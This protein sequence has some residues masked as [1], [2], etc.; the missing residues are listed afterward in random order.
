M[1]GCRTVKVALL[2]DC[3]LPRLGGI[4]VQVHD[5]A[6]AL[7]AAGHAVEVFTATA[8]PNGERHGACLV[9]G[10]V[11]VHRMAIPLPGGVPVN[12]FAPPEVRRRLREGGFDV[13]HIHMGVV[14]PFATDMVRVALGLGVPTAITWHCVIDRSAPAFRALG[15]VRRWAARGAALSA[16]STMAADRI[17]VVAGAGVH[18][19]V[20]GNGID[21]DAWARPAALA[22][23]DPSGPVRVVS[24]LRLARRKRPLAVLETLRRARGLVD[25][26]VELEATILGDGPQRA[27]LER[28]LSRHAMGWVSLPGRVSREEL[29]RLHW[30]SD[31]YLSTAR[32]EAFGIAALEARTAGLPVVARRGTGADDFV[33]DGAAGLLADDD[34]GLA[35]AVARLAG[36]PGL[37]ARIAGH[38]RTART[39]QDW[40]L[41]VEATV[42]EYVRAI[43]TGG[44]R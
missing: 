40:P 44:P 16:V 4:E 37:R 6:A 36:D 7:S 12:P 18:V 42:A 17:H 43:G 27:V 15:Q 2:S 35:T 24:A 3:Y 30:D 9:E 32:L 28:Y 26:G 29:R 21:A 8:G 38:N 25:P 23:R 22:S 19:G 31:L 1:A 34:E 5:L 13:A 10:E 33:E 20:L 11:P 14:S 41:V 39:A